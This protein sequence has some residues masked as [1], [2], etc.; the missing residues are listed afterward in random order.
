MADVRRLSPRKFLTQWIITAVF[1]QRLDLEIL[2][3]NQYGTD[4]SMENRF[5]GQRNLSSSSLAPLHT[6]SDVTEPNLEE[7]GTVFL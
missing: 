4:R 3:P 1:A 6:R 5:F 2:D 7:I